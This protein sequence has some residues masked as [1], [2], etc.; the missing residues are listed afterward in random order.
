M[1]SLDLDRK[2][3]TYFIQSPELSLYSEYEFEPISVAH[4]VELLSLQ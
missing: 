3:F 4:T 1:H 2:Y